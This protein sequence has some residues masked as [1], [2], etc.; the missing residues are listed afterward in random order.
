M[1]IS[2]KNSMQTDIMRQN[3]HILVRTFELLKS[4]VKAGVETAYLNKLADEFIRSE[5]G[6]PSFLGYLDYPA[7]ICTSLNEQVI[8]GI[9][10]KKRLSEGDIIS[11]DIGV[12]KDGYHVDA[13]R[14]FSVGKVSNEAAFLIEV[15]EKSFFEGIK[16]AKANRHL[17]EISAAIQ[18][19][20]ESNGFSVVRSYVGHGIGTELHEDPQV[21]N[22]KPPGRGSRLQKGM[23]LAIEPMVNQGHYDV[24][25]LRDK[26]TVVTSD[27]KLSAH[28]ENTILITDGE[29][30]L[31]THA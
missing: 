19:Y 12:Y 13:A 23:T 7:S 21:P 27:G 11:I 26:W 29:P 10:G 28:Y 8:H 9:P 16:C 5:G 6:I 3:G 30:E 18:S 31:L 22:Y 17:H 15:T 14:T 25:V 1:G 20:A 2:I 4:E 24:K